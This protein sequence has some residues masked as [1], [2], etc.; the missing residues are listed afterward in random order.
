MVILS[1][2]INLTIRYSLAKSADFPPYY[3]TLTYES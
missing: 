3:D 1:E 2:S